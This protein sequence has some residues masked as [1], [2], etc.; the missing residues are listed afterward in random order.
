[1]RARSALFTLFG[2]A[3]RPSGGVAW[4]STLTACMGALDFSAQATRTALHRMA[5]EGWVEPL[6][7]GRYAAYRLTDRGEERLDAAAA[8]IYR[9]RSRAWDGRWRLLHTPT[10]IRRA[11]AVKA[12]RW[13]GHGRLDPALWV[14]PHPPHRDVLALEELSDALRFETA[15]DGDA[16]RN[17][18][19]VARAWDLAAVTAAHADFLSAWP[20]DL[21]V[22]AE[23]AAA[24]ATRER[25]VHHWRSFLF[26]DPGLPRPL[27]PEG[28]RG[29]E[30]AGRFRLLWE[31]HEAGAWAFYDAA[32]ADLPDPPGAGPPTRSETPFTAD[33]RTLR[34]VDPSVGVQAS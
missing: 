3:V 29:A 6:R 11:D 23:P 8:R 30:A 13:W 27:E 22:S 1:M 16:A 4:L 33:Q 26:L 12:L 5:S 9:L 21:D 28:W 25:L 24:F 14:S 2:D 15:A 18:G 17:A 7:T 32:S 10:P 31:R 19:V 20:A 34:L